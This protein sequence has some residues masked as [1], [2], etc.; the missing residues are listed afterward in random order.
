MVE[1]ERRLTLP[2][3]L[4]G[5][6][7]K[8]ISAGLAGMLAMIFYVPFSCFRGDASLM[9]GGDRGGDAVREGAST[10]FKKV[11]VWHFLYCCFFAM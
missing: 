5:R 11:V 8:R 10:Y 4:S 2:E 6:P 9:P 7:H 1:R 3:D